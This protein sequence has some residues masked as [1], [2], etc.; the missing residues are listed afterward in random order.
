[1]GIIDH[2]YIDIGRYRMERS[3][4]DKEKYKMHTLRRKGL[5]GS[6]MEPSW[7]QGNKNLKEKPHAK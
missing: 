5:P 2:S 7:N 6:I 4:L 3:K 1:M